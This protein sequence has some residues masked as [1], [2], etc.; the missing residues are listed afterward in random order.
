MGLS[1]FKDAPAVYP[2]SGVRFSASVGPG[3]WLGQERRLCGH[4]F[5]AFGPPCSGFQPPGLPTQVL[6]LRA[7]LLRFSASG[8][9]YTGSQPP[10]LPAQVSSLRVPLLR[11]PAPGPPCSGPLLS[12][13][14]PAGF[15]LTSAAAAV[16]GSSRPSS[17]SA[18]L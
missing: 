13:V 3:G 2:Q 14:S 11:F 9:P 6:S 10:G 12:D 17:F 7:S 18:A 1:V 15:P 4:R 16:L 5:S 8:P